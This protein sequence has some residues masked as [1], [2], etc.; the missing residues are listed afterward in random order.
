MDN[1]I[2]FVV[3]PDRLEVIR[4]NHG[5]V[6]KCG[7]KAGILRMECD[8]L[9]Q[10]NGSVVIRDKAVIRFTAIND[11]EAVSPECQRII[12]AELA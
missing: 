5:R 2:S 9:P 7:D 8:H 10:V 12:D 11:H 3:M 1:S 6:A 4:K